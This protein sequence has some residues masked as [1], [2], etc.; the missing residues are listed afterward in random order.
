M[1]ENVFEIRDLHCAYKHN[2][3]TVLVIGHLD[4]PQGKISTI[5]GK[6]GSGKSTLVETL[7]MMN[8]TIKKGSVRFSSLDAPVI[9]DQNIWENPKTLSYIRNK[10]FSFIFQNDYLMPYYTPLENI[11]IGG[12]IQKTENIEEN[13][14]DF[15]KERIENV[16]KNLGIDKDLIKK[17]MPYEMSGGQKQRL[18]FLRAIAKEYTVMLGDEPTGNLDDDTSEILMGVLRDSVRENPLRS[19]VLV[20]HNISLSIAGSDRIIVLTPGHGKAYEVRPD[21]IFDKGGSGWVNGNN[22]IFTDDQLSSLIR[23]CLKNDKSLE[24]ENKQPK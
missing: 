3:K 18:S 12:L 23:N 10:H 15:N 11:F 17:Q 21:N 2:S 16:Y 14:N 13:R 24:Y 5:L 22:S 1:A 8:N 9:I 20:S 7:G 4:I 19:A 6:S